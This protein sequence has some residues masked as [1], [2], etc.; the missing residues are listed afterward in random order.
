M[1]K[2]IIQYNDILSK[3]IEAIKN[4][5]SII[6]C[7]PKSSGKSYVYNKVKDLLNN[8]GYNVYDDMN[9]FKEYNKLNGKTYINEK[10][11]IEEREKERLSDI[12]NNYEY[13]ETRVQYPDSNFEDK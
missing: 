11:W 7:G 2:Y 8:N 12:L 13:I 1:D 4:G 5:Y 3:S 10:F 9:D 6:I